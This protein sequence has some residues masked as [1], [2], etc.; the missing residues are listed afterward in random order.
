[1]FADWRL[2][3]VKD[4]SQ[5]PDW[6]PGFSLRK[7]GDGEWVS[8]SPVLGAGNM[9]F[10]KL[11]PK[12]LIHVR[13]READH[14]TWDIPLTRFAP[15]FAPVMFPLGELPRIP[16][17]TFREQCCSLLDPYID[18]FTGRLCCL[19]NSVGVVPEEL[20]CVLFNEELK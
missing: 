6:Y 18:T 16:G 14:G 20:T 8:F 11:P 12:G 9:G 4:P 3:S 7:S 1:M 5:L 19:R 10:E 2:G 13:D 17:G 15:G